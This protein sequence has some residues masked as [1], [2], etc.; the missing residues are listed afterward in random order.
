MANR[1]LVS[2]VA[3]RSIE[4]LHVLESYLDDRRIDWGNAAP[5]SEIA[6]RLAVIESA[7]FALTHKVASNGINLFGYSLL[8]SG[9]E[10][11]DLRVEFFFSS[12]GLE[13]EGH[14]APYPRSIVGATTLLFEFLGSKVFA[15]VVS[16]DSVAI[17]VHESDGAGHAF[18][19]LDIADDEM[20]PALAL[21]AL[22][23]SWIT[24]HLNRDAM[25]GC[26][27]VLNGLAVAAPVEMAS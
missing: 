5:E 26:V 2:A 24:V 6:V 16:E 20:N 9:R 1:V 12:R 13:V 3:V 18:A 17:F 27:L 14:C 8:S 23:R 4:A 7:R 22:C 11:A 25:F 15:K 21:L 10:S 19:D